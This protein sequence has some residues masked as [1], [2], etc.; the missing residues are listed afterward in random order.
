MSFAAYIRGPQF[1]RMALLLMVAA[2]EPG[3]RSPA[4]VPSAASVVRIGA[5]DSPPF[6]FHAPDG[7]MV[8]LG[9]DIFNAAAKRAALRIEWVQTGGLLEGMATGAVDVWPA[10]VATPERLARFH[11]TEP[12]LTNTFCLISRAGAGIHVPGGLHRRTLAVSSAATKALAGRYFSPASV[13]R[14]PS[15]PEALRAVCTGTL[16]AAMLETRFVGM[17]MV[18]RPPECVAVDFDIAP[19]PKIQNQLSI[20]SQREFAAAAERLR[21][22]ITGLALDGTLPEL[23]ERWAPFSATD[24]RSTYMLAEAARREELMWKLR[25]FGLGAGAILILLV[26][27]ARWARKRALAAQ[28][29]AERANAAK[30]DFLANISHEIRTPLNGIIGMTNLALD[31]PLSEERR[32]DVE[33]IRDSAQVLLGIINDVLDVSKIE[34]GRMAIEPVDFLL[35]Q[36]L[37]AVAVLFAPQAMAKGLALSWDCDDAIPDCVKGDVTRLQ[38]I[39]TNYVA[40]AVKFTSSGEVKLTARLVARDGNDIRVRFSVTDTGIGI[41]D[42]I[43]P[44][45]FAKFVQAD[46]S[47][48]RRFGGTGLGLAICRELAALMGGSA[49]LESR[50]GQG[51]EFWAEVPLALASESTPA[52]RN[53]Q[54]PA[55]L[56]LAWAPNV[57]LA[58]D[59]EVN[60]R[61]MSRLLEKLGCRVEV[62]E[63]GDQALK[64][65]EASTFD[66]VLMDC[67]MP[68][69]DGYEAAAAIRR[70][71]NGRS[72]TPIIAV[73]AHAL[74]GDAE[75]CYRAGMDSYLHKPIDPA[76]LASTV[77]KFTAGSASPGSHQA[78]RAGDASPCLP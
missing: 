74:A 67:Q 28:A 62:A 1:A 29:A 66:L 8:G 40:N 44:K 4:H 50:F 45:L 72:H 36:R 27:R 71:E 21:A 38:Q 19:F 11:L 75:R 37:A 24:V 18:K 70:V 69:V 25:I 39:L 20:V 78:K 46:V 34:A 31:G 2:W 43:Q 48:T 42:E 76:Q 15:R 7:R 33:T 3:G 73:T 59:N 63:N 77:M 58:E 60:R 55:M 14:M 49:G 6:Y 9:V 12:W 22:A 68:E 26:L 23:M 52:D 17:A 10:A 30:S 53:E 54:R 32:P 57:L 51:S 47:T 35:R 41:P 13:R 61:V 16:D 56:P 65:W 64:R 5:Y